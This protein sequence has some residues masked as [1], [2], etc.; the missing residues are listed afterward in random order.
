MVRRRYEHEAWEGGLIGALR[1][2]MYIRGRVAEWATL[3]NPSRRWGMRLLTNRKSSRI[4]LG[5]IEIAR[6]V[7]FF[8][9]Q[10]H[11]FSGRL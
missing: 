6:R 8:L 5:G 10:D 3:Q 11:K 4:L 1:R 2:G 7:S 9:K